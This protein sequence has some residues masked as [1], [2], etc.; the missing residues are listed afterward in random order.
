M[1]R[2]GPH[3]NRRCK[4]VSFE[5]ALLSSLWTLSNQDSYREIGDRFGI[6]KSSFC[7]VFHYI[8]KLI[9]DI[10]AN[11]V[12]WPQGNKVNE[13][14]LK[15]SN[16]GFPG[17]V[18]AI[19]GTFIT[20]DKP[21]ERDVQNPD[22]YFNRKSYFSIT[23]IATCDTDLNFTY[24]YAGGPSR[25]HDSRVF[26]LSSL[27]QMITETPLHLFQNED[28]HIIGDTGF[29]LSRH[30]MTPY[31]NNGHLSNAQKTYNTNLSKARQVIERAF[32]LLKCRFRRL[33]HL[34][35]NTIANCV[36]A[37]H[38]AT[39]LHNICLQN[40]Y[41]DE[42]NN[43]NDFNEDDVDDPDV[44]NLFAPNLERIQSAT[45]KRNQLKD[46]YAINR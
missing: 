41:P 28:Q 43:E 37:V 33:R 6:A 14:I 2:L 18:G 46:S 3:Y 26:Y 23:M 30:L 1:G 32:G 34:Q 5:K 4:E 10:L 21:R 25:F 15:F 27:G 7:K 17:T 45:D 36:K 40:E 44:P 11:T 19:D 12:S 13:I 8:T 35:M 22:N 42:L 39:I 38:A 20:I 9:C 24:V 16:L 29:P 31:K